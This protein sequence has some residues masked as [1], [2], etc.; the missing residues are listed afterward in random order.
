MAD[1]PALLLDA[2]NAS[3]YPGTGETWTDLSGNG[4]TGTLSG[5]TYSSE[6]GGYM[7]FNNGGHCATGTIGAS[8]FAHPHT[9]CCWFNRRYKG[10]WM[11]LFTTGPGEHC[12]TLQFGATETGHSVGFQHQG[13][14][15]DL[16]DSCDQW[17]Y[18]VAVVAGV[19]SG[20]AVSMYAYKSGSLLTTSGALTHDLRAVS[21]YSIGNGCLYI[22]HVAVY[23]RVLTAAEIEQNYSA[24]KGRFGLGGESEKGEQGD[25]ASTVTSGASTTETSVTTASGVLS[26]RLCPRRET[27]LKPKRGRTRTGAR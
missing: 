20:S 18:V 19:T 17:I 23:A 6:S 10:D 4:N 14:W 12:T 1:G 7:V 27:M 21:S 5:A 25:S 9:V 3:S 16:V 2:G 24:L 26:R 8:C 15:L 13:I 11:G 22:P